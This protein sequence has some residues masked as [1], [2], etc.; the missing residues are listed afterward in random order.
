[1]YVSSSMIL[2]L[3]L[4]PALG[5][6]LLVHRSDHG[7]PSG[8]VR[9]DPQARAL[10][11]ELSNARRQVSQA[12]SL[13]AEEKRQLSRD[14]VDAHRKYFSDLA[15]AERR[16]FVEQNPCPG[17]F[18]RRVRLIR[19]FRWGMEVEFERL[20][21]NVL[22]EEPR[23]IGSGS[24]TT[25][26]LTWKVNGYRYD[27]FV[28]VSGGQYGPRDDM[29]RLK[30]DLEN[31]WWDYRQMMANRPQDIA[32]A[33]RNVDLAE[34]NTS[35]LVSLTE[36]LRR[37]MLDDTN[38]QELVAAQCNVIELERELYDVEWDLRHAG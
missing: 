11:K 12:E 1:M 36:V 37:A 13:V 5:I 14:L 15:E 32:V 7:T 4:L 20:P 17:P 22:D 35:E 2:A 31:A 16:L 29:E 9:N 25:Y 38:L 28:D 10:R 8:R 6:L 18:V 26:K 23:I 19:L 24:R 30:T 33:R 3:A 34:R 27:H 21:F